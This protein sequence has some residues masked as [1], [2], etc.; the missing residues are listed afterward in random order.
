[1]TQI[2]HV[3]LGNF[4]LGATTAVLDASDHA[5]VTAYISAFDRIDV[6]VHAVGYVHQ[7]TIEECSPADWRRSC[8]ITLDSPYNVLGAAIP[9]MKA[10]EGSIITIGSIR[11]RSRRG[12]ADK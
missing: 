4:A 7:G 1:M 8:A 6:P 11:R 12:F 2:I 5:A 9:K 10:H 3:F